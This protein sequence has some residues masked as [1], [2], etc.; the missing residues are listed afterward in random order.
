ML[1]SGYY[2]Y[3]YARCFAATIWQE[4]CNADPLSQNTG[5]LLRTNFFCH[6][7]AKDPAALLKGCSGGDIIRNY[8]G[9]VI[10]EIRSLCREIGLS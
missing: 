3:L 4:K 1:I 8:D 7:G 2:S 5:N 10:P 9:G 6:G